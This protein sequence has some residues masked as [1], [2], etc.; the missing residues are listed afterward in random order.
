MHI[1]TQTDTPVPLA[2]V[3]VNSGKL[4]V[5]GRTDSAGV[6]RVDR[7]FSGDWHAS[8]RRIGYKEALVD[9]RIDN[10]ENAFT[11]T[12]DESASLLDEVKVEATHPYSARLA[13]FEARLLRKD[14]NA[15]VT[16]ADIEKRNPIRL[17]QM[18]RSMAGIRIVDS[19]GAMVALST[20]GPKPGLIE[21]ATGRN[22]MLR[23]SVDGIVLPAGADIDNVVP[24]DVHGVEVFY[25]VSRI[26]PGMGGM[27]LDSWCGLIAIW[28]RDR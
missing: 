19:L 11:V 3:S 22:C 14:A 16:R 18:L 2:E 8:I 17:S 6:F 1:V 15:V 25:G 23:I 7:L 5:T 24:V 13:D 20:R 10:G 21:F 27:R 12:L 26:P 9:F 4:R 28:T